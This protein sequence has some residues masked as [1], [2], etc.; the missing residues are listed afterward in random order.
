M[1]V[2]TAGNRAAQGR[3]GTKLGI[4]LN[5]NSQNWRQDASATWNYGRDIG[6]GYGF[7]IMA[8]SMQQYDG[9]NWATAFWAFTDST[10]AQ[11]I[12][13][14]QVNQSGSPQSGTN[15]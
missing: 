11:Y 7:R 4:A 14:T 9:A 3:G 6:Y 12:L 5:Y 8:G 15:L 2:A 10:G 1:C 13:N